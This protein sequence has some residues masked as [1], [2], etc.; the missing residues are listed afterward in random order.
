M[1]Q[2]QQQQQQQAAINQTG[3][4]LFSPSRSHNRYIFTS[5]YLARTH[6]D[7]RLTNGQQHEHQ[8]CG[9]GG[10]GFIACH[11]KQIYTCSYNHTIY[12][13]VCL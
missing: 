4:Q 5:S 2:R 9:G 1:K 11:I 12:A 13:Y 8:K 10:R 7:S 3:N 6:T